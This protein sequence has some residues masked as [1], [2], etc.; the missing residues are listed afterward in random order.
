MAENES[1]DLGK[2]PR[3][4]SVYRAVMDGEPSESVA[5]KTRACLCRTV[6]ALKELI[7]FDR[8][9]SAAS[10]PETLLDLARQCGKGRDFALLFHDIAVAENRMNKEG[11]LRTFFATIC[12]RYLGQIEARAFP[13]ERWTNLSDLRCHLAE[14]REF[15]LLTGEIDRFAHKLAENPDCRPRMR[16]RD[17]GSSATHDLLNES[18]LGVPRQ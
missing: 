8:L 12:D 18:L 10:N 4:Q 17:N 7:P 6:R 3:W 15:E 14:V 9:L 5:Q 16:R 11:L 1:L 2:S 13:S